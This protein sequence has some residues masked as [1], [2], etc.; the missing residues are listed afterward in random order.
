[1]KTEPA[2]GTLMEALHRIRRGTLTPRE[3]TASTLRLLAAREPRLHAWVWVDERG[4]QRAAQRLSRIPLAAVGPLH[5]IPLGVKDIIDVRGMPTSAGVRRAT[6]LCSQD[7]PVCRRL[8]KAGGV[9]LGKTTTT[10][11]AYL[12]PAPTRNPFNLDHTPGGSSSGSA[13][14]VA[15]DMCMAALGTQT[16]GSLL[17]PA[18]YCGLVGLKPTFDL[19]ETERVYPL[20]WNLD[21]VGAIAKCVQDA[22]HLLR[23]LRSAAPPRG[24][25][26]TR[27]AARTVGI[28]DRYFWEP[29]QASVQSAFDHA[30]RCIERAGLKPRRV[31][32]PASFES[33]VAAG[34]IILAAEAAAVHRYRLAAG[35]EHAGP[36]LRALI[37]EGEKISA[38]VYLRAHQA[39][40]AAAL[41]LQ[42]VLEEVG[43][44]ATPTTPTA[45]PAGL[46]STGSSV[47][48]APFTTFGVPA[49]SL[50]MGQNSAGLPLGLQ[51]VAPAWRDD[52]LLVMAARCE[53]ALGIGRLAPPLAEVSA[54][55]GR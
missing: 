14:A 13:A 1:M 19:V 53:R 24:R 30:L 15:A 26:R 18:S 44:L 7:A 55:Q 29:C 2:Q 39:R 10:E 35:R 8:R 17:R 43:L 9:L 21:H 37:S 4:A 50:P 45:A 52:Q 36:H 27:A 20:S 47:L 42:R 48:N 22:A 25:G 32:L 38:A 31:R 11:F 40:R 5:G 51:L 16:A 33:G 34:E 46:A 49:L 41:D 3:L 28:P 12:D 6:P 23:V 54:S